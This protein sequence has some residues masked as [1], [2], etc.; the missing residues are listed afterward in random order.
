MWEKTSSQQTDRELAT[1]SIGSVTIEYKK[2]SLGLQATQYVWLIYKY[3]QDDALWG[4][5]SIRDEGWRILGMRQHMSK[6][7]SIRDDM[8]RGRIIREQSRNG[9]QQQWTV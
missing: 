2:S 6:K 1:S 9:S 3:K 8:G 5:V 4:R 7:E